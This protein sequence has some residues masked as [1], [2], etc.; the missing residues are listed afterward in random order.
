MYATARFHR[1]SLALRYGR[2]RRAQQSAMSK[3]AAKLIAK[4]DSAREV[5]NLP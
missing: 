4:I 2:L 1:G 3:G 5:A